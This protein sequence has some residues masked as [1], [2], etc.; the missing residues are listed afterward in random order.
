M[1]LES[2]F[3]RKVRATDCLK[4]FWSYD[5]RFSQNGDEMGMNSCEKRVAGHRAGESEEGMM[6]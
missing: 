2:L 1:S 6:E 3:Q 5:G 4:E